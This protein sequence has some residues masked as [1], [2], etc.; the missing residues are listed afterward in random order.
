MLTKKLYLISFLILFAFVSHSQLPT[1]NIYLMTMTKGGG[2]VTIKDPVFLSNFNARGYNNQPSFIG[3]DLV[4]FTTNYY[5]A[6]QTEIAQMDLFDE[7]LTRITYTKESE[8]SPQKMADKDVFSCVRVETDNVTQS[9][10]V[11]PIDG[12]GYAKRLLHNT[13]NVGYYTWINKERVAMFLVDEPN[14][15]LAIAD[16]DSEKR[17]IVIDKIGRTLKMTKTGELLFVHKIAPDEWYI[18]SYNF[19]S[20]Q[21]KTITKTISG[22]E[23]FELLNDGS[24]LMG[25]GSTLHLFNPKSAEMKWAPIIDLSE[26]GIESISRVVSYKNRLLI[27]D[28]MK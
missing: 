18:K 9:L 10:S 7:T 11:Y 1:S 13:N 22:V 23:D 14:H 17:K 16:I 25:S 19:F 12:I 4:L 5:S 6:D 20:N 15:N 8:Y 28:Q 2:K 26:Y 21:S 24:L 3:D 27:V